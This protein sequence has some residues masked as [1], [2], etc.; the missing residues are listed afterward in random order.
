VLRYPHWL[1]SIFVLKEKYFILSS[2]YVLKYQFFR[3]HDL[4]YLIPR[5]NYLIFHLSIFNYSCPSPS[6]LLSLFFPS[7]RAGQ[8]GHSPPHPWCGVEV[9]AAWLRRAPTELSILL[10]H[11]RRG[12]HRWQPPSPI[13]GCCWSFSTHRLPLA[14]LPSVV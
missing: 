7:V 3:T 5:T 10:S 13:V 8:A 14:S 12:G 4:L 1:Y 11:L 9:A 6:F 2:K